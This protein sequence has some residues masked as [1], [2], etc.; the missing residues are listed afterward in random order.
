MN[1]WH[2]SGEAHAQVVATVPIYST[3]SSVENVRVLGVQWI[4]VNDDIYFT[5]LLN[6]RVSMSHSCGYSTRYSLHSNQ[7]S[8]FR[9]NYNVV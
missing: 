6:A 5:S 9:A 7:S 8:G 3:E 2:L 1:D 4:P